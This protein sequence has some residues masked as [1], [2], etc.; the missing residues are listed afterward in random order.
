M[1]ALAFN[2]HAY[3]KKLQEAGF[4]EQQAE[5]LAET[6]VELISDQLASKDDIETAHTGL[7]RDIA[8]LRKDMEN[9]RAE[10]KRDIAELRKDMENIRAE[11]TRDIETL[12]TELKRDTKELELRLEAKLADT[13]AD[14]IRW[15]I[16]VGIFQTALIAALLLKLVH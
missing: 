10:L 5:V 6:Q 12:R 2:T 4:T 16:G 11:L 8:E 7:K 15:M 13:K 1:T 9:I 3:V 14:I